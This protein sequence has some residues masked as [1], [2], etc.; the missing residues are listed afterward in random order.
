MTMLDIL[1][2]RLPEGLEIAK[3]IDKANAIQIEIW[4][5]YRGMKTNCWLSKT[6]APGHATRL[7]DKTIATAMLGFAIQLKDFEMADYWK[8]K[9]LDKQ[10]QGGSTDERQR[11]A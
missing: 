5:A 10:K 1:K 9:I 8:D 3:V 4:F 6:C 7:C 2:K 11:K